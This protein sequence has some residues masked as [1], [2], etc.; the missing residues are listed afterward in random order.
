[1]DVTLTK[2]QV[3]AIE[4]FMDAMIGEEPS[5][6]DHSTGAENRRQVRVNARD[7]LC[8]FAAL[9]M[10]IG[11]ERARAALGLAHQEAALAIWKDPASGAERIMR[12]IPDG[13][14]EVVVPGRTD[15]K[16]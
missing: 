14:D 12:P 1:M 10:R 9:S 11:A 3:V 7:W 13:K 2:N 6:L 4:K 16:H 8:R 15:R 5:K